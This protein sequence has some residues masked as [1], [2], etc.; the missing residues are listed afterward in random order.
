MEGIFIAL[1]NLF[2]GFCDISNSRKNWIL[3]KTAYLFVITL[4]FPICMIG[5]NIN[6]KEE[7]R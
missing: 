5:N 7:V 3:R 1:F 6:Y 4:L 2:G